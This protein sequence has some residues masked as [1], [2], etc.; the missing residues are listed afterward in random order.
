M[1]ILG[2]GG[3]EIMRKMDLYIIILF[4][5]G[6]PIIALSLDTL[7]SWFA[8][9]KLSSTVL[10]GIVFL[11]Y[12]LL[13]G[14]FASKIPEKTFWQIASRTPRDKTL[15]TILAACI[16][17]LLSV[18]SSSIETIYKFLLIVIGI[19]ACN[20]IFQ[21]FSAEA[22]LEIRKKLRYPKQH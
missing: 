15:F 1:K 16:F 11:Y 17:M 2:V 4:A 19:L 3:E 10:L 21:S 13:D 9:P 7:S 14:A 22:K 20:V 12:L 18:F 6:L 5:L 8:M